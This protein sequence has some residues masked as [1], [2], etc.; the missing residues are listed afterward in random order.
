MND[1]QIKIKKAHSDDGVWLYAK[2]HHDSDAFKAAAQAWWGEP[3]DGFDSPTQ[4]WWR[5]VPDSTGEYT[6]RYM[7]AEPGSRGAFAVTMMSNW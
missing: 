6:T 7:P 4:E 2:G 5:A 3:L 1:Q